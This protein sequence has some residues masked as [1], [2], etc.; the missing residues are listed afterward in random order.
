[1]TGIIVLIT[2]VIFLFIG[3]YT[4][5]TQ[6]IE[7]AKKAMKKTKVYGVG[8]KTEEQL[9]AEESDEGKINKSLSDYWKGFIKR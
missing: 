7:S 4:V 3:R 9:K 5:S 2:A 6:D 8:I 1:M